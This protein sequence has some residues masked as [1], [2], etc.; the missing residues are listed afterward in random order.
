[1]HIYLCRHAT[2]VNAGD[3]A[4]MDEDRWLS[5]KGRAEAD[6]IGQAL[7]S[8]PEVPARVVTSPLVR[9]VQ[10]AEALARALR[11]ARPVAA[12]RRLSTMTSPG[13]FIEALAEYG[14]EE[15][16][17]LFVGHQLTISEVAARLSGWRSFPRPFPPGSVLRLDGEAEPG[18]ATVRYFMTPETL[19]PEPLR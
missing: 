17:V 10:T 14:L 3:P 5:E 7:A 4:P 15:E 12:D 9:A 16:A 18:G 19:T 1:M 8:L 11:S 2:A 6:S 13:R